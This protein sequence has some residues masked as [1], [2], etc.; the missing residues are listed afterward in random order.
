MVTL[1]QQLTD[2]YLAHLA[3]NPDAAYAR[4]A[5]EAGAKAGL[6]IGANAVAEAGAAVL[7][8]YH[9][10]RGPDEADFAVRVMQEVVVSLRAL[11]REI[12]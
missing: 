1:H 11:S 12:A 7:E 3:G 4:R 2:R 10:A 9:A 5:F 8:K 6:E